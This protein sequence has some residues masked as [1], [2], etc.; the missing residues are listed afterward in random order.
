MCTQ[1][2]SHSQDYGEREVLLPLLHLFKEFI[3]LVGLIGNLINLLSTCVFFGVVCTHVCV[4]VCVC[5]CVRTG[6]CEVHF[7]TFSSLM[8]LASI[9]YDGVYRSLMAFYMWPVAYSE[10]TKHVLDMLRVERK[11]RG[12]V[13]CYSKKRS[14]VYH[15][16]SHIIAQ[17]VNCTTGYM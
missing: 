5:V 15:K 16:S 7:Y 13:N 12:E 6:V 10:N 11:S 17:F 3:R 9:E 8:Q 14:E 4:C 1:E 2:V